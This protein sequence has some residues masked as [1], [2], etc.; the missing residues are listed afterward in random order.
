M[1]LSNPD[2]ENEFA[3]PERDPELIRLG[4]AGLVVAVLISAAL[5][6]AVIYSSP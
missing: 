4:T 5:I 6:A 3:A 1:T 2:P